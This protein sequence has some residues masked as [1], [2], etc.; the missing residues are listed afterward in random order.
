MA[1]QQ[2]LTLYESNDE[3][4]L[5]TITTNVPSPGTPLDLTGVVV[6]AFV[7]VAA[8]TADSDPGVWTGSTATGEVVITD[9][10]AG[11]VEVNVPG[12]AITTT[13][14]WWRCDTVAAGKRKTASYGPLTIVDL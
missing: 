8:A 13:K 3:T 4:I 6:E 2:A 10:A 1:T 7:K 5:V 9:A 14:G 11:E 12:S